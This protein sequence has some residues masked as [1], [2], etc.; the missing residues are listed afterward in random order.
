MHGKHTE[1]LSF[2]RSFEK[3]FADQLLWHRFL[4]ANRDK[5]PKH[6]IEAV[7]FLSVQSPVD[8]ARLL[9]LTFVELEQFINHPAYR[10]FCIKKRGG[11]Q[12]VIYAP[13]KDLKRVQKRINFFLQSYYLWIK[14][15]EV[16]GFV[17]NPD[18]HQKRCNIVENARVHIGKKHLLNLDLCDFF[19]SIT[20]RRVKESFMSPYFQFSDHLATALALLVTYMGRLPAGAPS[21]P[22]VSNFICLEMDSELQALSK[23]HQWSYSRYADDLS[24]SSDRP[25]ENTDMHL[26]SEVI[27]K[28]HFSLNPQKARLQ[29]SNRK[30]TVTGLVV[31]EKVNIDRKFIRKTRAMIH[32]LKENGLDK[33]AINHFGDDKGSQ[34]RYK[35]KFINR[36]YGYLNFIGQVRG[37]NDA[38]YH[39]MHQSL[40]ECLR[41]HE[42]YSFF[43]Q[44]MKE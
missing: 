35:H 30:Q 13:A 19:P 41:H 24:F 34:I 9:F 42:L 33:A 12:R 20:A 16:F 5:S 43:N 39:K 21:S 40:L 8:L 11:G 23:S 14:P 32:D 18:K 3:S 28:H 36:L 44:F 17:I 37:R 22:A 6:K 38:L 7:R 4:K 15:A 1:I 10:K 27:E 31:N 29:G 25:F 26:I 2:S